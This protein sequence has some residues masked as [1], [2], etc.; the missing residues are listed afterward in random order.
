MSPLSWILLLVIYFVN[1]IAGMYLFHWTECPKELEGLREKHKENIKVTAL[2]KKVESM[3]VGNVYEE[4]EETLEPGEMEE[5]VR[6]WS[7]RGVTLLD[8]RAG[9]NTAEKV[10]VKWDK[11]NSF[12]FAFTV[13]TTIGEAA[14]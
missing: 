12:F 7:G 1:L 13:V 10:C 11:L 3:M 2:V 14:Q 4:L 6:I 9:N 8:E 5:L